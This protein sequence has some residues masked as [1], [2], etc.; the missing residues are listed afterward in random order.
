MIEHLPCYAKKL[1][2]LGNFFQKLPANFSKRFWTSLFYF[3]SSGQSDWCQAV[4]SRHYSSSFFNRES[5]AI[6]LVNIIAASI[7]FIF[8]NMRIS[9][10]SQDISQTCPWLRWVGIVLRSILNCRALS[11]ITLPQ[12]FVEF[13]GRSIRWFS[14][15]STYFWPFRV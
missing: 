9:L 15:R 10:F 13:S 5:S 14:T 1:R 7:P 4:Y 2:R 6:N 3:D 12:V 8:D 11:I